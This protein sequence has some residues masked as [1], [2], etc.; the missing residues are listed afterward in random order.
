MSVHTHHHCTKTQLFKNSNAAHPF[1]GRPSWHQQGHSCT[2]FAK[3]QATKLRQQGRRC[4]YARHNAKPDSAEV[5]VQPVADG[6]IRSRQSQAKL[7]SQV[8]K[9][10][11]NDVS[12][13]ADIKPVAQKVGTLWGLLIMAL[14]YV[15]HSTTG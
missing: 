5:G 6:K 15:H 10:S 8:Q 11:S 12:I 1:L 7:K 14:A 13:A 2:H 3:R 4:T 9:A